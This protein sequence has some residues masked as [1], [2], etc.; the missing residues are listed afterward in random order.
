MCSA[1]PALPKLCTYNVKGNKMEPCGAKGCPEGA[2]QYS[3]CVGPNP[4]NLPYPTPP[5]GPLPLTNP[6]F[7]DG[8]DVQVMRFGATVNKLP[9]EATPAFFTP[10]VQEFIRKQIANRAALMTEIRN[11]PKVHHVPGSLDVARALQQLTKIDMEEM[12]KIGVALAKVT[13]LPLPKQ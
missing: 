9:A 7:G 13:L 2:Q 3:S 11:A 5:Q 12:K 10:L 1:T 6:H 8:D 4:I